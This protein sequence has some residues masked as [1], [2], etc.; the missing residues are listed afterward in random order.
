[1]DTNKI[2]FQK[3]AKNI[4][5]IYQEFL[6]KIGD[7]KKKQNKIIED[8]MNKLRE[9]KLEEVRNQIKQPR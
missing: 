4:E 8:Y 5:G 6:L 2:D 9:A 1:M 7:L 3:V